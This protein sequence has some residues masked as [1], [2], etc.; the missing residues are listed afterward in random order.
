MP[1][2]LAVLVEIIS[3]PAEASKLEKQKSTCLWGTHGTHLWG[4]LH[5][6]QTWLG[7]L[8]H[9]WYGGDHFLEPDVDPNELV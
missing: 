1:H 5:V 2:P 9:V 8:E 3:K 7:N 4:F 6:Y